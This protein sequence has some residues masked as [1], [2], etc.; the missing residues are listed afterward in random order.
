[1]EANIS[2][3]DVILRGYVKR[4]NDTALLGKAKAVIGE[5]EV[6]LT[7]LNSTMQGANGK[8]CLLL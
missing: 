6:P 7:L 1:M 2:L 8:R 5:T 4:V 3:G